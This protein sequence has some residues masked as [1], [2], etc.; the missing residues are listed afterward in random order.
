MSISTLDIAW[1]AGFLE[2]EGC[3][4]ITKMGK[5]KNSALIRVIVGQVQKEP[6]E[7]LQ[8]MYGGKVH[9]TTTK[10][11]PM[12]RWETY[13]RRSVQIMMTIYPLMSPKRKSEIERCLERW[14]SHSTKWW[15]KSFYRPAE[16]AV[17]QIL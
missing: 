12:Y 4:M 16:D 5:M 9:L 7:R 11:R 6:L 8:A 14:K 13:T 17:H 3:F 15:P 1:S 2:G 10:G